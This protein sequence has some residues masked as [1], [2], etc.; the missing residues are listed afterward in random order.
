MESNS[1][2]E[3]N[4][5]STRK[6]SPVIGKVFHRLLMSTS[7]RNNISDLYE[8]CLLVMKNSTIKVEKRVAIKSFKYPPIKVASWSNNSGLL[9]PVVIKRVIYQNYEMKM[10]SNKYLN[11]RSY[12]STPTGC[13]IMYIISPK[14][15]YSTR[16][17]KQHFLYDF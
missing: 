14:G 5:Q 10:G 6:I 12:T 9:Y 3:N 7:D 17:S 4:I 8:F 11:P 13:Y 1:Y 2:T 15:P 16:Y